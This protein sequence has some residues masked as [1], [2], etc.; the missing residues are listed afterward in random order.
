MSDSRDAEIESLR[1]EVASL[2]KEVGEL[3]D[4]VRGLF[5][6]LNEGEDYEGASD[7]M[8]GAEY[9]RMNT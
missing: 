6:M 2:R 3:R 4:F 9:G 1:L 5:A 8:G 7:F